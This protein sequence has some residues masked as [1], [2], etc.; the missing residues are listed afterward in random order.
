MNDRIPERSE[1]AA[2]DT[3][4]LEDI[5]E[6]LEAWEADFSRAAEMIGA[7]RDWQGK[8]GDIGTLKQAL[9]AESAM[10]RVV[11]NL[12]SY[13]HMHAD[14]DNRKT[15]YQ[16]LTGRARSLGARVGEAESFVE[17]E[18]MA[19]PADYLDRAIAAP[20]LKDYAVMLS[21]IARRRPH[22][23]SAAEERIVAM[24]ADMSRAPGNIYRMLCQVDMKFEPAV[25]SEG[26]AHE[27]TQSSYVPML[28]SGDRALRRSAFKNYYAA[29]KGNS[30]AI[31]AAYAGSVK[32]DVFR[33]RV[34]KHASALDAALFPDAVPQSVYDGL[35]ACCHRHF[36]KLGEY[37]RRKGEQLGL[38]DMGM[39][40]VYV[41]AVKGFDISLPFDEAYALMTDC[42]GALGEDYQALLKEAREK[43]WIDVYENV[44]KSSGAYSTG[45]YDTHPY[46]LLN[47]HP[48]LDALLTA[49]HEMGHSIHTY[50]ANRT[51]P[52]S[53]AD[54]SLFV[55]EVASTTNEC[56]VVMEL[57][58][59]YQGNDAAQAYLIAQ[60]LEN[61]RTT[62][63]RQTMFAEFE[64]ETHAME[65]RGE[66]LTGK[67]L[68]AL[69]ASLNAQYYPGVRQ[70][71]EIACEWM[72]I[73]HFYSAF[74]VY[75]YA[76]GFSAAM[77][78][79]SAIRSEGKPAVDRYKKFLSLGSSMHPIDLL[80][81][82]GVDMSGGEAVEAALKTFDSMVDRYIA[83]TNAS[84]GK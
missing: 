6:S 65:E 57:M 46:A 43:R 5:Y 22:T 14:E 29:Y 53:T 80:K 76:T 61:F 59:R 41:A 84:V 70:N 42:L 54:Y 1:I 40:D 33:A 21:E 63:F 52:Y 32:A 8:L 50:Y 10:E 69:Y 15:E 55:A 3:W 37:L 62:L 48:N 67:A 64:K 28:M 13:A 16:A 56:L 25:D 11:H 20:E 75:K 45:T 39:E 77:A 44:G 83:L 81:V 72:R 26:K 19:Q 68:N 60:L 78:L 51:Q 18:L 31:P 2:R 9:D 73:P 7:F 27:L 74:Y 58:D 35:I 47:Y 4:N 36:G 34:A 17:P 66:P 12:M 82:A 24:T 79:A 71:E 49:A 38:D 23:L 30:G